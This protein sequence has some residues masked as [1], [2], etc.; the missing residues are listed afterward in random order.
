MYLAILIYISFSWW[1]AVAGR[2]Q[3]SLFPDST[4]PVQPGRL[5]WASLTA[6]D[7]H[8][9]PLDSQCQASYPDNSTARPQ[10]NLPVSGPICV[11]ASDFPDEYCI[12]TFANFSQGRGL[13]VLASPS[14]I[15][16]VVDAS[17]AFGSSHARLGPP[18]YFEEQLPGRGK[19]LV[20]NRTILKGQLILLSTPL[21]M[22]QEKAMRDLPELA[23]LQLQQLSI[24]KL[25]PRSRALYLDLAVRES[26]AGAGAE[27]LEHC[28]HTVIQMVSGS[29]NTNY[30][31]QG[32]FGGD[33]VEDVLLTNGFSASLGEARDGFGIVVPEA[34]RLNHDCR[35]N[36]RFALDPDS[37]ILMVHATR[38]IHAGEEIT[39]S[40]IDEKQE[41]AT[42]QDTIR[43]NWGFQC[44]CKLCSG[45]AHSRA[46]SDSRLRRI[47]ILRRPLLSFDLGRV[48]GDSLEEALELVR[49]YETEALSGAL[50]EGYMIAAVWHCF[51][52]LEEETRHWAILAVKNWLVWE[53]SGK[54][55]LE[56]MGRLS[57]HPHEQWCWGKK[58]KI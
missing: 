51:W 18:P 19:G 30:H 39:F 8:N 48:Q 21:F 50:A 10:G 57:R 32:H 27:D 3:A 46:L 22:I 4:C 53:G 20:C 42:R 2:S 44:S 34:A 47:D 35:P 28:S 7:Q 49:L 14:T 26:R 16:S 25:P 43:A 56:M 23:R 1:V 6:L 58:T 12:Y 40:Y 17:L 33:K 41:F 24:Q 37:L 45:P 54:A 38:I 52:G 29:R 5:S 31:E 11:A 15:S 55:N 9:P 13:S 36:A